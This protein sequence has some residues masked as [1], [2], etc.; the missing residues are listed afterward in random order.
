MY[1]LAHCLLL[2]FTGHIVP[3]GSDIMNAIASVSFTAFGTSIFFQPVNAWHAFQAIFGAIRSCLWLFS[4]FWIPGYR[5]RRSFSIA[6]NVTASS[7]CDWSTRTPIVRITPE[8]RL[9]LVC[10]VT[11]SESWSS[12]L[13][14]GGY[15]FLYLPSIPLGL[16]SCHFAVR[17]LRPL[18][19]TLRGVT[20]AVVCSISILRCVRGCLWIRNRALERGIP[21]ARRN[22]QE[23]KRR[24]PRLS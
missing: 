13:S 1:L 17:V 7:P 3:A 24:F 11:E 4:F 8:K 21:S 16:P 12:G 14:V 6:V 23:H 22:G 10:D 9:R 2:L 18:L 19:A 5:G 20:T 15:L